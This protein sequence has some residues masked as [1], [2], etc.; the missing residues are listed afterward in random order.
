MKHRFDTRSLV[1]VVLSHNTEINRAETGTR[2]LPGLFVFPATLLLKRR[3][4]NGLGFIMDE[5]CCS[6]WEPGNQSQLL[7]GRKL[8]HKPRL[9]IKVNRTRK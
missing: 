9:R 7:I 8:V 2:I 5:V 1:E 6:A 3:S 4:I